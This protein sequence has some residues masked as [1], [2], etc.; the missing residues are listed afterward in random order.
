MLYLL[1][2]LIFLNIFFTR[3]VEVLLKN[4]HFLTEIF[5]CRLHFCVKSV[6][7]HFLNEKYATKDIAKI[8]LSYNK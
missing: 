2:K 1:L 3:K 6:S 8:D 5:F 4:K 7:K